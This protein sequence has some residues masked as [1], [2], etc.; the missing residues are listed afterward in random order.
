MFGEALGTMARTSYLNDD[1]HKLVSFGGSSTGIT[2]Y[3]V[4]DPLPLCGVVK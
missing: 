4:F 1:N 3:E 2:Q